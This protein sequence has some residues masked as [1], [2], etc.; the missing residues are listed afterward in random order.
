IYL[1]FDGHTTTGT[2]WN[3]GYGVT[4]I[5][6]PAYD[7]D[8]DPTTWNSTELSR[9]RNTWEAVTEDFA[10]FEV[11]VTTE[12]PGAEALRKS[13]S[14]DTHWGTRVVI[15]DDT[16]ANCGCGGH[17]YIGSFNDSVDEPV[18]VY[19][20]SLN[21]V[22][23]AAS[24]EVGH[25]LY[26]SHDGTSTS[27]YYWGHSNSGP[28]WAPIMG[29]G[30]SHSTTHWS[31]GEYFDSNN[32]GAGANYNRG[33]DDL[34]VITTYNGFGYRDDDH[35]DTLPDATLLGDP[36]V[37]VSG[38]IGRTGDVDVF[39][40]DST[41]GVATMSITPSATYRPNL[42]VKAELLDAGGS[43]VASSND[44]SSLAAQFTNL[45]LAAGTYFLRVDGTGW[46]S[47]LSS[48]PSGYT[49]Y[50]SLGQYRITG[51][52]PVVA[53]TDPPATPV[54]LTATA[55]ELFVDLTWTANT[56][57]DLADYAVHRSETPGGPYATLGS[58][59]G[60]TWRDTAVSA[61]TTYHYVVTARDVSGNE[62]GNSD[63]ASATPLESDTTPPAVPTG[64]A[65]TPAGQ[66]IDLSWDANTTDDDF[67]L[68][69]VYRSAVSG[70]GYTALGTTWTTGWTDDT[71]GT[72]TTYYYV[73][74][75]VDVS[76]NES[77]ASS[78]VQAM[79]AGV[80]VTSADV[81]TAAGTVSGN[82]TATW[83]IDDVRQELTET[84]SGGKP[85]RRHDT[86]DH[87]WAI[88]V[89]G[90]NHILTV[91]ATVQDAGDA[92]AG[93][94]FAWASSTSGPWS[95]VFTFEPGDDLHMADLG[96]PTGTV[97]LRITD[98]DSTQGQRSYDAIAID[99]IWLGGGAPP[100]DPPAP[101]SN[102]APAS[103]A[104]DV[105]LS[106][107]LEWTSSEGATSYIV[108]FDGVD[109]TSVV[110]TSWDPGPLD[111]TSVH[112]WSVTA[113]NALGTT[114]TPTWSFTTMDEPTATSVSASLTSG[115]ANAAKGQK[116]GTATVTL[117]DDL[118][119][120][121]GGATVTV[122]FGAPF[123]DELSGM[124]S[125]SGSASFQTTT[126]AKK[127]QVTA[128]V[129]SVS[130]LGTLE[131]DGSEACGAGT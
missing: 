97:Y 35:A 42:D 124:T 125:G 70:S 6:S 96:S 9:I 12:D 64:V 113:S 61:G 120:P 110:S 71:I 7:L 112:T 76:G 99:A 81:T 83:G 109:Q 11:N 63:E 90:G 53:D 111:P 49:D 131:W 1:D 46:G 13:G 58:T 60:T 17:A 116:Y 100:T 59:T 119:N 43:V 108:T 121:V 94:T 5:V 66:A 41:G 85:S 57:G 102:V 36:T 75:A 26:L 14:G 89:T 30:Y 29:A 82:H 8:G 25:A 50:G 16:F 74:T 47:P 117:T 24:H 73:V 88:Q 39:R 107:T 15:T 33:P 77:A 91:V 106:P 32:A 104:T 52:L 44:T 40:I 115:T 54:G 31:A 80:D 23:E 67:N 22:A 69:T 55:G 101:F 87:T 20:S 37:L 48:T 21:G 93:F 103:N 62:S 2:S 51:S 4:E 38:T 56:E 98:T 86:L 78:E 68:F 79:V 127:P 114:S 28:G 72:N 95:P 10:A 126:S 34:A 18:F 105:G 19:N 65:A 45:E 123:S 92:D 122:R 84:H 27:A 130:G 118:G 129:V 3:S 128:C